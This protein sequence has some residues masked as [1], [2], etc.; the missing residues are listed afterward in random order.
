MSPQTPDSGDLFQGSV[1]PIEIQEEMERSFLEYS[2]SVIV[3]RALPD[4]RDGLKPVH[5]RILYSMF[6]EGL[7]PDRPHVK[8]SKVVGDVMGKFHPHGDSAIYEA[9]VRMAQDFSLRHPL[10]DGHG[11]FGSPDP[12]TGAAA[13]RYTECRLSPLSLQLMAG[14]DEDTVG[15]TGNYDGTEQEPM[16]LPSRFPN[17]LVNGSQGI[18]VGMATN[19][20]PHNLEEVVNAAI[21]LI[22]HPEATP[23]ELMQF[24]K[25]PDFPTGAKILGRGGIVDA[26]R[27]GKGSIRIRA[28]AEIVEARNGGQRIVVSEIPYQTSVEQIE[29]KI[30]DLVN[31][32]EL[33]GIREV[34]NDSA[35]RVNRLVVELKRDANP[36]VVLNNLYKLTPMESR[37]GV[38]IIALVDGVPRTLNLAQAL[39]A[40][41]DHQVEVVRRRSEFRLAKAKA[42]A[43]IVEG[44]LRCIDQLDAVISLIRSSDD[45]PAARAGL[46]AEPFTFSEVQANHILDMTLGRL[47]RLGRHELE[48][49]MANL[50]ET[51]AFLEDM[52]ANPDVLNGVVKTELAAVRD[53]FK[54][55]RR[56]ELAP[57][58]GEFSDEDL[59][60]DEPRVVILTRS[61]YIKAMSL[62]VFRT[63]QRGGKGVQGAK[64]KEE[65]V[66]SE[67][68]Y[69]TSH[70]Y[71]LFFSNKGRVYRI[72]A[73]EL[74]VRER[75]ARGMALVNVL[76]LDAD[77]QIAT[78]IDTKAYFPDSYLVFFT[79]QGLVKKTLLEEYDKSRRD[80]LI[81]LALREGDELV[82]V[83]V[84]PASSD[85]LVLTRKGMGIRFTE[86]EVRP[87]GRAA[88]GVRAIKLKAGDRVVAA[89][90]TGTRS[91]VLMVTSAGYA[92]R[93]KVD[94]FS[95]Q[96]RGGMG[97]RAIRLTSSKGVLVSA[98]SVSQQDE[99]IVVADG[100]TTIRT[101][102]GSVAVQ[103]RDATGV[104][105]I[106]L[107]DDHEVSSV[108][109]VVQEDI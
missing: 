21:H 96:Q 52:L 2:M 8:C 7:R 1:E 29:R 70:S 75:T 36:N 56:T 82:K 46:I 94:R 48:E 93:T 107:H 3:S 100:G 66:V 4:A 74:G 84:V 32:H 109:P 88:S 50:K 83:L 92:K 35:G 87:M 104:K 18:A 20:P 27:T 11:N 19:I 90:E 64:I 72:K 34:Q 98:F 28:N 30:A 89:I 78:V 6:S 106:D 5:R 44:L 49:E 76:A 47:T 43:H 91:E 26:Y 101:T 85:L 38:N 39:N 99:V 17:L 103:G 62:D 24:V 63:Q 12:E 10:I 79:R 95:V 14:I 65:D 57:D 58:P 55:P 51:I 86:S 68:L 40:Y 9:L 42:R 15:F 73:H 16:V 105:I 37:F 81:A 97:V 77:E 33:D 45:R 13:A 60:D 31:N 59:I 102:V 53:E 41:V 80:G 67:V 25:G 61:G 71:L 69:T 108:T 22:D 54:N 23:D